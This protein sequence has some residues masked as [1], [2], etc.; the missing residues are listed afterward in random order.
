MGHI[1]EGESMMGHWSDEYVTMIVDCENREEMLSDWERTFIDSLR[2][3]I[4]DGRRPTPK[5]IDCLDT[6]WEKATKRG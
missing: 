3:Q 5:Q 6:A 4:E 1:G 2:K